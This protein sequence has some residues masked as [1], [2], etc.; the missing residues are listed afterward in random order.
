MNP[1]DWEGMETTPQERGVPA[2]QQSAAQKSF[3]CVFYGFIQNGKLTYFRMLLLSWLHAFLSFKSAFQFSTGREPC[4]SLQGKT[5]NI[6]RDRHLKVMQSISSLPSFQ[7]MWCLKHQTTEIQ[8]KIQLFYV[9]SI[10]CKGA[11]NF[12]QAKQSLEDKTNKKSL[13]LLS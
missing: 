6:G 5:Q 7:Q 4:N 13:N 2:L 11:G 10:L 8:L 3:C 12:I 9:L 1:R